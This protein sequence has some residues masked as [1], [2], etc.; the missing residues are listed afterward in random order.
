[1]RLILC[2][3]GPNPLTGIL[4][5][6][7]RFGHTD[8]QREDVHVKTDSETGVLSLQA[9][10]CQ[11]LQM[12]TRSPRKGKNGASPRTFRRSVTLPTP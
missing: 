1:M 2:R 9:N 10:E 12:G 3:V 4:I 7:G 8:P 6:R 5:R 11:G